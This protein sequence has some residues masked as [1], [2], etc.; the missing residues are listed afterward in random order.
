[1]IG[2]TFC[3]TTARDPSFLEI[4]LKPSYAVTD[5]FNV[6]ANLYYSP[7]WNNYHFDEFYLSGTAKYTFG[8]SGFSVSGEL[9]HEWLGSTKAGS[10]YGVVK[11]PDY[12]TWNV[13]VSYAWKVLTADLRYS[14]TDLNKSKCY[15]V[16]SDPG[17]NQPGFNL[18]S[19]RSNWCGQR[20]MATLSFDLSTAKD[21]K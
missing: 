20:I 13:G 9:G 2:G 14:G 1:V 5:A 16:T 4:Y 12:W 11:F 8:T 6:G 10:T 18:N 3:A 17:G 15:L 21:L 7:N 19:N